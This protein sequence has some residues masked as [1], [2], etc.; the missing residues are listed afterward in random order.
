MPDLPVIAVVDDDPAMRDALCDLLQLADHR[1]VPFSGG[2][3][4]L[5]AMAQRRFDLVVTDLRMPG[6]DGLALLRR[7]RAR[8]RAPPVIVVS[9]AA[10]AET[11]AQ[12]LAAGARACLD[13]PVAP[14]RLLTLVDALLRSRPD[15]G[16]A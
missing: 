12:A 1:P 10:D 14:D 13:K 15:P 8:G 16:G 4:L 11:R 6:L 5:A 7:L 2:R 9:S 3:E